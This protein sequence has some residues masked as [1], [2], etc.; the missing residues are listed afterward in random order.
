MRAN[1][2]ILGLTVAGLSLFVA[3]AARAATL[4]VVNNTSSYVTVSVD[5]NYGCNTADRTT[6]TIPVATG[7]HKLRAVRSD[8]GAAVEEDDDI[9]DAGLTWTLSEK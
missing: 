3:P 7:R 5:G 6:C 9:P 4:T 1:R 2:W 8:N